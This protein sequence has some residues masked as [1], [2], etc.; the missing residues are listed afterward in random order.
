MITV[1]EAYDIVMKN[2]PKAEVES[3]SLDDAQGRILAED[4]FADRNFPP[5]DRVT[6]D[7][8]A[9]AYSSFASG[10][11][12]FK[13]ESIAAAGSPQVVLNSTENC[14]ESMTGAMLPIN[15]DT[16]IRYEDLQVENGFATIQIEEIR[17]K[18]NVHFE[19][20]DRKRSSILL[21]SGKLI[22]AP[23]LAVLATA[24]KAT[25]K[26]YRTPSVAIISSGD[27]LVDVDQTPKPHQIR[28]SNNYSILGALNPLN[29]TVS[30]YHILDDQES[31]RDSINQILEKHDVVILSGGV[32]KGKFDFIP[33]ALSALGVK[34]LFHKVKQ[35]PGKP[36]WFGK[37][38]E[39]KTVF[40]LPGNPVSS[41]MC[42][43]KY[44]MPWMRKHLGGQEI[45]VYAQLTNT[46]HF[47]ADLNY[48]AQVKLSYNQK[49]Q[50]LAEPI[51]GNG[52]GDLANLSDADAFIELIRGKDI[53]EKGEVHRII[54]YR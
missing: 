52:S 1:E 31:I 32:S 17:E 2:C 43:N 27:E 20:L 16:V 12:K 41:F 5:F 26:V 44:V 11:R 36:F 7:G 8:I 33:D 29:I 9:I 54:R 15:S 42:T 47:K 22:A 37:S 24:G 25:V 35:R 48:F 19:G 34:K 51:E 46:V 53:Y 28:K 21:R 4:V 14:V 45:E 10:T 50:L 49:G 18:Q 6:M 13:I 23:E 40:A 30:Q 39:G 38:D 3:T